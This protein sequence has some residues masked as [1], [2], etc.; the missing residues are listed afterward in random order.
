LEHPPEYYH[1][2]LVGVVVHSGTAFAGHYYSYIRER[3]PPPGA[4]V[5]AAAA[6]AVA[7]GASGMAEAAMGERWHV[8]D[9]QRVEPYNLESL[10]ADA[11]GGKYA[12]PSSGGAGADSDGEPGPGQRQ[13][14]RLAE[15]DRP[16]SAY[17]LFYER[18][19]SHLA[20]I[21]PTPAPSRPPS[22]PASRGPLGPPP[23]SQQ[24]D[25][26]TVAAAA[27][28][29]FAAVPEEEAAVATA[30]A[31]VPTPVPAMPRGIRYTVMTQNLQFAFNGHLLSRDYFE[32]VQRLVESAVVSIARK[33][34]R[35]G[36][37]GGPRGRGGSAEPEPAARR[38]S[39][40]EEDE[41]AVL[42]VR[43]ATEVGPRTHHGFREQGF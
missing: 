21:V 32:F 39:P 37:E 17:M 9:D 40:E 29:L 6:A 15:H 5:A 25:G 14:A 11:F 23:P 34:Q 36:V 33:S 13:A 31:S 19:H 24:V 12:M 42:S 41:H 1:Y 20:E 2:R 16:N 4:N 7:G 18:V 8:Y 30:S 10:E 43:I 27:A 26:A 22:R 35:R 28:A 38:R 3:E